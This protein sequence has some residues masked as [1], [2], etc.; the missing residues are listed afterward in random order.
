MYTNQFISFFA[1]C[2][3]FSLTRTTVYSLFY[4]S[5]GTDVKKKCKLC[6]ALMNNAR[7]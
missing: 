2:I 3:V 6:K 7:H 5:E 1:L 4:I